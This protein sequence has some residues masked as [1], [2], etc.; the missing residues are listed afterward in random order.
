VPS[1]RERGYNLT[2]NDSSIKA[3]ASQ[4]GRVLSDKRKD[5]QERP[6]KVKKINNAL[7]YEILSVLGLNK[8][9]RVSGC[10]EVLEFSVADDQTKKL[11]KAWFC[12]SP[13]CP[14]CNWRKSMK[15]SS[16]ITRVV[17]EVMRQR[18]TARWLFLTLTVKNVWDGDELNE[19]LKSLSRGFN[20]LMK[21]KKVKKN[22]IG[23]VRSTEITVNSDNGSYNQHLHVLLCMKSTYFKNEENYIEQAEWTTLWQKA[24]KLDYTPVVHVQVV[25]DVRKKEVASN[26]PAGLASAVQETG[27]YSVKD[28]DYLTEDFDENL[29]IVGDLEKGLYKKRM[30][31]WGGLL[32][33]VHQQLNL[34]DENG[35]LVHITEE[36]AKT[37]ESALVLIARWNWMKQ[38]YFIE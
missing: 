19:S 9:D 16:Q 5:G 4:S 33:E 34:D 26:L 21:Y 1:K 22:L 15:Q 7:Y 24:M 35:D 28:A 37:E 20:R 18:K 11:K 31:G 23:F 25:R 12:K 3:D 14:I 30:I 8:A 13:L 38:N 17:G 6:W 29:S 32:K 27:K 10:A 2:M 36:E